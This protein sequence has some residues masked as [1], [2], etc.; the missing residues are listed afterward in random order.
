VFS[1]YDKALDAISNEKFDLVITDLDLRY[2]PAHAF[3]NMICNG[4]VFSLEVRKTL[5]DFVPIILASASPQAAEAQGRKSKIGSFNAVLEKPFSPDE[6]NLVIFEVMERM[7]TA[8]EENMKVIDISPLLPENYKKMILQKIEK[9][10]R[11][12][13]GDMSEIYELIEDDP[14]LSN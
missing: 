5:G 9:V 4:Y 10:T 13:S 8:K 14:M 2:E 7:R 6:L 3:R 1:N 12:F 11:A